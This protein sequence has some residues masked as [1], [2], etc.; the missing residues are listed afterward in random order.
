MSKEMKDYYLREKN[1]R[2]REKS[3][4][5]QLEYDRRKNLDKLERQ[6][7]QEKSRKEQES[8]EHKQD[9]DRKKQ[10]REDEEY[11]RSKVKDRQEV[12][13]S[14]FKMLFK[15]KG[16]VI[17]WLIFG[18]YMIGTFYFVRQLF[19]ASLVST[20]LVLVT[21]VVLKSRDSGWKVRGGIII[22]VSIIIGVIFFPIFAGN[23]TPLN[24]S[25]VNG[26]SAGMRFNT[27][28]TN[29]N[30]VNNYYYDRT[31]DN[32]NIFINGDST[33]VL[34]DLVVNDN[35][36]LFDFDGYKTGMP[37]VRMEF[38]RDTVPCTADGIEVADYKSND[39][40]YTYNTGTKTYTLKFYETYVMSEI[41]LE[42]VPDWSYSSDYSAWHWQD[43]FTSLVGEFDMP[44][45]T[46]D[47]HAPDWY[48]T[49]SGGYGVQGEVV[50]GIHAEKIRFSDDEVVVS[51]SALLDTAVIDC[52]GKVKAF[53][54]R[55]T[56]LNDGSWSQANA[57]SF[58]GSYE[59]FGE[60]SDVLFYESVNNALQSVDGFTGNDF[61]SYT[62]SGN[63]RSSIYVPIDFDVF[64]GAGEDVTI[65]DRSLTFPK[66]FS[67]VSSFSVT[68]SIVSTIISVYQL[69]IDKDGALI[70]DGGDDPGDLTGWEKFLEALM[71]F[72][73][74]LKSFWYGGALG[75]VVIIGTILLF[76]GILTFLGY[77]R[78]KNPEPRRRDRDKDDGGGRRRRGSG[79]DQ[80]QINIIVGGSVP[81]QRVVQQGQAQPKQ[82]PKKDYPAKKTIPARKPSGS[83][84]QKA[85]PKQEKKGFFQWIM[86]G[87]AK[88]VKKAK[89]KKTGRKK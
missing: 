84:I 24:L 59:V 44:Y 46:Y 37:N 67:F 47:D 79:S 55:I 16:K 65:I 6:R 20:I 5:E 68:L 32:A 82:Y 19:W 58:G 38:L 13:G 8:F 48:M 61:S 74:S 87:E 25:D 62:Y 29:G 27:Y 57:P 71:N 54:Y 80:P 88:K 41:V 10:K 85:K 23:V 12:A 11:K 39:R 30:L 40:P 51:T 49:H 28:D 70:I 53:D 2:E 15:G 77:I 43:Y 81:Q 66:R 7:Y 89:K 22:L 69:N 64:L 35:K 3:E 60:S 34:G 75:K 33:S 1:R 83:R 21:V 18:L 14:V 17:F 86:S 31:E 26:F 76:V 73:G 52:Y 78:A 4:R 45:S 63:M 42:F 36:M 56:H 50:V 72:F 9:L